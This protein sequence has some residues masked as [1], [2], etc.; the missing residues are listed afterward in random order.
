MGMHLLIGLME[1]LSSVRAMLEADGR[2]TL[3]LERGVPRVA[4]SEAR[5]RK[6]QDNL[7]PVTGTVLD[8]TPL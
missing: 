2:D 1:P 5:G 6:V 4:S 8:N 3:Q 7:A